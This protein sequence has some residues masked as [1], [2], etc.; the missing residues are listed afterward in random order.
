MAHMIQS[1]PDPG[2][3]TVKARYKTVKARYKTVKTRYKTFM[4]RYKTV[5]TRYKTVKARYKTV[6]AQIRQSR[7]GRSAGGADLARE[8]RSKLEDAGARHHAASHR[9]R[10]RVHASVGLN[11]V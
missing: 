10:L 9:E 4:S 2:H 1:R 5:N 3:K 6:K 7:P 8:A 11:P